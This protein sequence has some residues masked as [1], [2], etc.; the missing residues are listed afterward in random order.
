M[1]KHTIQVYCA[2]VYSSNNVCCLLSVAV[3][4][5]VRY[6]NTLP[7]PCRTPATIKTMEYDAVCTTVCPVLHIAYIGASAYFIHRDND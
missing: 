4:E 7:T 2:A 1:T 6:P 3:S 5:P